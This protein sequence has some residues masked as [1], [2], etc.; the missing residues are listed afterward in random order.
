MNVLK[1]VKQRSVDY[2]DFD[3]FDEGGIY[4]IYN[5]SNRHSVIGVCLLKEY[6]KVIFK[7]IEY[8]RGDFGIWSY[9]NDKIVLS[10]D[11]PNLADICIV[12]FS[13]SFLI[14]PMNEKIMLRSEID[15]Y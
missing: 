4:N 7:I 10:T 15:M 12:P 1:I 2:V 9:E 3:V 8:I 11:T 6:D 14:D 5:V 13:L